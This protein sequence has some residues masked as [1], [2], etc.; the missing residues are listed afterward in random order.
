M[1]IRIHRVDFRDNRLVKAARGTV[2]HVGHTLFQR[3]EGGQLIIDAPTHGR[4][5]L[6]ELELDERDDCHVRE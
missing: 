3:E 4:I 6:G 1:I 5:V 2:L